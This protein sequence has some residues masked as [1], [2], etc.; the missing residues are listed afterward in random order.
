MY[1]HTYV[2]MYVCATK[3]R[4]T[5]HRVSLQKLI[6]LVIINSETQGS[7]PKDS[8]LNLLPISCLSTDDVWPYLAR[9]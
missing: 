6:K 5:L 4:G 9:G 3:W 8:I 2:C 1:V 7:D